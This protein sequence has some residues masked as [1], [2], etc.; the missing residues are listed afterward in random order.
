MTKFLKQCLVVWV[1]FDDVISEVHPGSGKPVQTNGVDAKAVSGT[2]NHD[3]AGPGSPCQAF[4]PFSPSTKHLLLQAHRVLS[5]AAPERC[6]RLWP[7]GI[8]RRGTAVC[9]GAD[10]PRSDLCPQSAHPVGPRPPAAA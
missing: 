8:H 6:G 5:S 4:Q 7:W 10:T 1:Q 2:R 3:Q 9:M